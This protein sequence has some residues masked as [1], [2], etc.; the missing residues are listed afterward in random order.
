MGSDHKKG[1]IE[2]EQFNTANK[3]KTRTVHARV[4]SETQ[5]F[6]L[7]LQLVACSEN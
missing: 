4:A 3:L 5:P 7:F 2:D 6:S 1:V